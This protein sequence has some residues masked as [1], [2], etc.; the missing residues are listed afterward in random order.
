MPVQRLVRNACIVEAIERF[1][2]IDLRE[3]I[4][5]L[6]LKIRAS[7]ITAIT[8]SKSTWTESVVSGV[9]ISRLR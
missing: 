2:L 1:P 3:N 4:W 8:Q 9:K 5:P 6:I 7:F